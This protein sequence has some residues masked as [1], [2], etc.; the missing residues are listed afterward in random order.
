MTLERATGAL[1]VGVCLGGATACGDGGP[2]RPTPTTPTPVETNI[3][4]ESVIGRTAD[5]TIEETFTRCTAPPRSVTSYHFVD[6]NTVRAVR[7]D[8]LFD[9]SA[10]N[11]LYTRTGAR[12]AQIEIEWEHE[13]RSEIDL[14]FEVEDRGAFEQRD[15]ATP[16]ETY[17]GDVTRLD[18]RGG[19]ELRDGPR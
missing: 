6:S 14:T 15:F 2:T 12:A 1:L 7:V 18:Y 11:W 10:S 9:E 13:G 19:F 4:P 8:G 17:C 3:A 5:F 16:G